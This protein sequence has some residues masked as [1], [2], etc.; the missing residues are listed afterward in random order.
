MGVAKLIFRGLPVL[1]LALAFLPGC[2]DPFDF[3]PPPP[4][5]PA[6]M[7]IWYRDTQGQVGYH[8]YATPR[9]NCKQTWDKLSFQHI[10]GD[11]PPGLYFHGSRIQGTP[12][13]PGRWQVVVKFIGVSCMGRK[14]QDET[15]TV[16]LYI[17]GYA[18]R[19]L[20]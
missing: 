13:Q 18:P 4:S 7:G 6:R 14:Y 8:M 3:G 12:T 17:K 16:D 5:R 9:G 20:Q 15:V 2:V 1:L 11:L 19:K 10:S